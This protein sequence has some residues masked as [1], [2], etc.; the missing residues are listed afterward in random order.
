MTQVT[1]YFY[2]LLLFFIKRVNDIFTSPAVE[3]QVIFSPLSK[4]VTSLN[5]SLLFLVSHLQGRRSLLQ[6]EVQK[7]HLQKSI[8]G[9][10]NSSSDRLLKL[11]VAGVQN[12]YFP[13]GILRLQKKSSQVFPKF[14][15]LIPITLNRYLR[16][17]FISCQILPEIIIFINGITTE[18]IR[19]QN[20]TGPKRLRTLEKDS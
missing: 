10:F 14:Y 9:I 3:G 2:F 11:F 4:Y 7:E 6:K 20:V 16:Q 17:S 18:Q 1:I 8:Q 12:F 5:P 15:A 13:E 19:W